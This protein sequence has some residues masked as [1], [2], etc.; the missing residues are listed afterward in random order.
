MPK[1]GDPAPW[2]RNFPSRHRS[3]GIWGIG[4]LMVAGA[5]HFTW[6]IISTRAL[7]APMPATDAQGLALNLSLVWTRCFVHQI[8]SRPGKPP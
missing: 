5:L 8:P 4:V 2:R 1:R 6:C 7:G 3:P